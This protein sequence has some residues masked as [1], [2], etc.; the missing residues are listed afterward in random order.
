MRILNC[1]RLC[2]LACC[3]WLWLAPVMA[4]NLVTNQSITIETSE[5]IGTVFISLPNVADYKVVGKRQLLLYAKQVGQTDVQI[6]DR[7]GGLLKKHRVYVDEDLSMVR[8]QL[9]LHYPELAIQVRSV[10]RVVSVTGEVESEQQ[11]DGVYRLIADLLGRQPI[12]RYDSMTESDGIGWSEFSREFGWDGIIEGLNMRATQQINV[13]V[14]VAQV[15]EEFKQS[16]GV[17]WSAGAGGNFGRFLFYEFK[18]EELLTLISALGDESMA[19]VLA[20]PNLTVMSGESADFLV[21]GEV[22]IILFNNNQTTIDFKEYGIGLDMTAKVL[23][24]NK[25]RMRLAPQVS[26]IERYVETNGVQVP[27]LQSRRASTTVELADGQSFLLGG[28][29]D[30]TELEQLS[31]IPGLGDI[32]FF[33]AAFRYASTTR[34]KTELLIVATV[35]LVEPVAAEAVRLPTMEKSSTLSRLLNIE[36]ER[37]EQHTE[38]QALERLLRDGGFML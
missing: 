31:K 32:P 26:A 15:T 33:G 29:M 17:Q 38:A 1:V 22:P 8:R 10:G 20:E 30:S 21:G 9:E 28:L 34:R 25:I 35:N 36:L 13:K 27:Q 24:N 6:F 11:R 19:E 23:N 16:V 3:L 4:M 12:K 14:S 2:L 7:E 5:D 18:A 37:S